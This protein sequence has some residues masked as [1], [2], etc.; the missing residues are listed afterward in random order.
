MVKKVGLKDDKVKENKDR[1][2]S[3]AERVN[4]LALYA[5]IFLL[6]LFFL[7]WTSDVLDF[8]K[9]ALLLV[10]TAVGLLAWLGRAMAE[11][12][13]RLRVSWFYLPLG[14]LL[15]V[16]LLASVFSLYSYGSFWGLPLASSKAFLSL[17]GL[18][19]LLFLL[20][21]TLE[22][23]EEV[24]FSVFLLLTSS[25]LAGLFGIFQLFG[26]FFL[27]FGFT[28][29]FSFNTVGTANAWGLFF[30]A[31]LP[32]ITLLF[33]FV[34]KRFKELLGAAF[35]LSLLAVLLVNYWVVWLVVLAGMAVILIFWLYYGQE[36]GRRWVILPTALLALAL[37]FVLFRFN[38]GFLPQEVIE[39]SPS[40]SHTVEI[41]TE[42]A[43]ER[44]LL[45]SGPG[46][47]AYD[48]ALHK[49]PEL[50]QT[51]FWNLRFNNG[52]SKVLE[53]LAV[54]G[55][56]GLLSLL[57]VMV[58]FIFLG[59]RN[60]LGG[61]AGRGE[62][63]KLHWAMGLGL[64]SSFFALCLGLFLYPANLTLD[65]L[66]WFLASGILILSLPKEKSWRLEPRR[67]SSAVVSFVFIL[68][69]IGSLAVFFFEG[70]RYGAEVRYLQGL[71]AQAAGEH[72]TAVARAARATQLNPQ[73]DLYWRHLAQVALAQLN[74]ELQQSA[75][76]GAAETEREEASQRIQLYFNLA[77]RAAKEATDVAPHNVVNWMRRGAVYRAAIG[78]AQDSFKWALNSYNKA[79]ELE[80]ANPLIPLELARTY[81][82][83][84][85]L[86]QQLEQR[87]L[88]RV[89]FEKAEEQLGTAL[90]LKPDYWPAHFQQA[91]IYDS[92]G[93]LREAISKLE[94]V[95]QFNQ[96]DVQLA[97][98]LGSYY[99]RRENLAKA[100]EE[101]ERAVKL[102]PTLANARYF[103][104][105]IYDEEGERE[106]AISEFEQIA[107]YSEENR[108][109]VASILAN[110]KR[111]LPA[112]GE[113]VEV[114]QEPEEIPALE[115]K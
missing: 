87:E 39:I 14:L 44:P 102:S 47:F 30:A 33:F 2:F 54:S 81:L 111:G 90:E 109:Q 40:M 63:D 7:P 35:L 83:D 82:A 32:L 106:K 114:P 3:W 36:R 84:A 19:L 45:G 96:Q 8:N 53:S 60:L 99:W 46:T 67:I 55:I 77:V 24:V 48:Y 66:F 29:A 41:A 56:L 15:A 43:K 112:L 108:R 25:L 97:F 42:V 94:E 107:S 86:R 31:L 88:A 38:L 100:K 58:S 21:N 105:L 28:K 64:L 12:E 34:Q 93:R 5:V 11:G 23:K 65:F 22:R 18:A 26:K 1:A 73:N 80:P 113:A 20:V 4:R 16:V 89:D 49:S 10:L 57:G 68:S 13:L 70:Q 52:A 103:L 50:N 27:P 92:Q 61:L 69:L 75:A 110:L 104:G 71:R 98:Q 91:I 62:E 72:Q 78:L 51:I 79:R 85:S 76:A 74:E 115:E 59:L 6:P 37:F 101:F 9:Q 17:L 95:K